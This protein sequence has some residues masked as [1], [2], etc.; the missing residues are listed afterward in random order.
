MCHEICCII[1]LLQREMSAV[2]T[3]NSEVFYDFFSNAFSH[4]FMQENYRSLFFLNSFK[5]LYFSLQKLISR[6]EI[7]PYF[8]HGMTAVDFDNVNRSPLSL[9][10]V[11]SF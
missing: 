9:R 2:A 10:R 7:D 5:T 6:S 8:A 1:I 4:S 11:E 3:N